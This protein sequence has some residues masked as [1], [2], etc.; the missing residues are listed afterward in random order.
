M[1][2]DIGASRQPQVTIGAVAFEGAETDEQLI[3][4]LTYFVRKWLNGLPESL[5]STWTLG[6]RDERRGTAPLRV[7]LPGWVECVEIAATTADAVP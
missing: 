3:Y 1:H 2:S 7:A 5:A 6:F 4:L